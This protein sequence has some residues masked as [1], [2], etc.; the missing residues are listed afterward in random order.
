MLQ[1]HWVALAARPNASAQCATYHDVHQNGPGDGVLCYRRR[2]TPILSKYNGDVA[3]EARGQSVKPVLVVTGV[4]IP[5]PIVP[6]RL[7]CVDLC[8][9]APSDVPVATL[10]RCA[11]GSENARMGRT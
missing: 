2:G 1:M 7:H 11:G 6:M 4:C 3:E 5:C 9:T 8:F 10:A